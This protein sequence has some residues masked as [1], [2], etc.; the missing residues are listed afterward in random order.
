ME[1]EQKKVEKMWAC[2]GGT[3]AIVFFVCLFTHLPSMENLET[4]AASLW[5]FRVRR[6][7]RARRLNTWKATL[8]NEN[9]FLPGS[10]HLDHPRPAAGHNLLP[11]GREGDAEDGLRVDLLEEEALVAEVAQLVVDG[12]VAVDG[13]AGEGVGAEASRAAHLPGAAFHTSLSCAK[14]YE[15]QNYHYKWRS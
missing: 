12:E 10:A 9:L 14:T 8:T 15:I 13:L 2:L 1:K 4:L 6:R 7:L 3:E 11:V 5:P